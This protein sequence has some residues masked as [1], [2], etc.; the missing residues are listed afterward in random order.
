MKRVLGILLLI[1]LSLTGCKKH[2][3]PRLSGTITLD[4]RAFGSSFYGYGLSVTTGQKVSTLNNPLDVITI[5]VDADVNN[6][7]QRLYLATGNYKN[8]FYRYGQYTNATLASS[9]FKS[10]TTFTSPAWTETGDTI[11]PY[12]IWLYRTSDEKYAKLMI[13]DTLT[14]KKTDM[15][16]PYGECT[17]EWVYQPNGTLTFPGK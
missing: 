8:S 5:L 1:V 13:T 2:N 14:M 16:F 10:L 3:A 15:P 4:N 9:A 12:Q 7:V 17:F 11:R 6:K